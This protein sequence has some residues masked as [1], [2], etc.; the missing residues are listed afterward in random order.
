MKINPLKFVRPNILALEPYST[1]RDEYSGG[2]I[3]AWIDA[4]ESP[5]NNGLNRYPDPRHLHLKRLIAELKGVKPEQVFIGGSGSD[6]AIDIV[7]RTFCEPARDNVVSIAP[8]YGV[9]KVS[10]DVNNIEFRSVLLNPD[11][12]LDSNKLLAACDA[13]T[14]VIWIC[15]PNNPTGNAFPVSQILGIAERFSGIVVVDE[16]Y[17]DFSSQPSMLQYIESHPNVIVLQT[18]SKA[19]GL[20]SLRVGMA[21]ASAEIAEIFGK[22][23][24]PYNLN[25]PT[26]VEIA[27]RIGESIKDKVDEIIE[28][29]KF[30]AAELEKSNNVEKVYP[31]DANFLLIKVEDANAM[32]DHLIKG[33]VIVRNRTTQ[34]LCH[35]CLR[36]TI[37]TREENLLTLKLINNYE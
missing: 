36:I 21:F 13:N 34:P 8:S 2:E 37:G 26:Q 1:A 3:T 11:Y 7:Y 15:S 18:F 17:V 32:Y 5:F 14:K 22:V 4:N 27:R 24:Y 33:G 35:N 16:A 25:G 31:S 19:W 29:R 9:Y 12:T 20:A 28:M 6:E 10:A 30:M 23:K